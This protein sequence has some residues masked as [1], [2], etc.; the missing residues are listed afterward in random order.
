V[1]ELQTHL[2]HVKSYPHEKGVSCP[3]LGK[4]AGSVQKWIILKAVEDRKM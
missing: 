2:K 4:S 3:A 1:F